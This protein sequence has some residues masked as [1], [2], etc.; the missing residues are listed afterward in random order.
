MHASVYTHIALKLG[1]LPLFDAL[2]AVDLKLTKQTSRETSSLIPLL[3]SPSLRELKLTIGK[4]RKTEVDKNFR[5]SVVSVIA[6]LQ[7]AS[8]Q[9]EKVA[10]W[11][12]IEDATIYEP[13]M[14]YLLKATKLTSIMYAGKQPLSRMHFLRDILRSPSIKKLKLDFGN[15]DCSILIGPSRCVDLS[16]RAE[17][18]QLVRSLQLLPGMDVVALSLR[19]TS[20]PLNYLDLWKTCARLALSHGAKNLR[21]LAVEHDAD[22]DDDNITPEVS[23]ELIKMWFSFPNLEEF[24][25]DVSSTN[26]CN[27]ADGDMQLL[28]CAWPRLRDLSLDLGEEQTLSP[29]CLIP[30]AQYCPSLQS[31]NIAIEGDVPDFEDTPL[32]SHGLKN[33]ALINPEDEVQLDVIEFAEY[34]F[35]LFPG[36]DVSWISDSESLRDVSRLVEAFQRVASLRDL[37]GKEHGTSII[38]LHDRPSG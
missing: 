1:P 32:L 16:I 19:S 12:Y 28:A 11:C 26:Q 37:P 29:T 33:L 20:H 13:V 24:S 5:L 38:L 4:P 21:Q 31:L 15:W 14:D 3:A 8:V 9:L 30:L 6:M 23:F 36:V 22:S 18:P 34:L 10:I 35:R 25:F 2:G 27:P 17:L 7:M